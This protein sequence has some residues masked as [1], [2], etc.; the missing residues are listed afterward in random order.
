MFQDHSHVS[1]SFSPV[2][3]Q[4]K[5]GQ[6]K[7]IF[8]NALSAVALVE[9]KFLRKTMHS[10]LLKTINCPSLH[11][12]VD[13]MKPPKR[14]GI[15]R[16]KKL[17][18]YPRTPCFPRQLKEVPAPVHHV[19][20]SKDKPFLSRLFLCCSLIVNAKPTNCFRASTL[21][22]YHSDNFIQ[23]TAEVLA[24]HFFAIFYRGIKHNSR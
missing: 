18:K 7:A 24:C 6:K 21:T 11:N 20:F 1:L 15:G 9:A 23:G 5:K 16:R 4:A 2:K 3:T 13:K 10:N 14:V 8:F 22:A 19:L 12:G 17:E